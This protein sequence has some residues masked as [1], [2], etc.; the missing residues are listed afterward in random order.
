[1]ESLR[2]LTVGITFNAGA[3]ITD[4]NRLDKKIDRRAH[5]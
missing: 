3:T 1:M 2:D 5:V 4:I